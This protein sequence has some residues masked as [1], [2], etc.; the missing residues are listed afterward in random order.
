MKTMENNK[1]SLFNQEIRKF[2]DL[3][4]KVIEE[5]KKFTLNGN[6]ATQRNFQRYVA[7]YGGTKIEKHMKYFRNFFLDHKG[8]F[9]SILTDDTWLCQGSYEIQ[10]GTDIDDPILAE[11]AKKRKI[12]LSYLYNAACE[13]RDKVEES[14]KDLPQTDS[15]DEVFYPDFFLLHLYKL[16]LYAVKD[17]TDRQSIQKIV[18]TL[19][20]EL[21]EIPEPGSAPVNGLAGMMK[22]MLNQLNFMPKNVTMPSEGELNQTFSSILG[23]ENVSKQL[24]NKFTTILQSTNLAEGINKTFSLFQ[25]KDFLDSMNKAVTSIIPP[26]T[27]KSLEDGNVLDSLKQVIPA[28]AMKGLEGGDDPI[29]TMIANMSQINL[30]TPDG[31]NIFS[32]LLPDLNQKVEQAI[33]Q[34]PTDVIV[35]PSN[36]EKNCLI[37][38]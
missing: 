38:F 22:N 35:K 3:G 18:S 20:S 5:S 24:S 23:D 29:K 10:Y 7:V 37:E 16:F 13:V 28:D 15:S 14:M 8:R 27:L 26:E 33:V 31:K 19:E 36:E 1:V 17:E 34:G 11:R 32:Q 2:F 21:G 9:L 4:N 25:D 6:V 12:N 30:Q